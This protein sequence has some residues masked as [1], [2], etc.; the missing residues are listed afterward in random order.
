MILV[1]NCPHNN[2]IYTLVDKEN[3]VVVK[4]SYT[5]E[6]IGSLLREYAGY[7][8]Y[9]RSSPERNSDQLRIITS[10][11][12]LYSRLYVKRFSGRAGECYRNLAYNRSDLLT[13]IGAY[14]QCWPVQ[15]GELVPLHGD[16]S[17]GNLIFGDDGVA[18]IDWEHFHLNAAPWGLDMANLLY[19]A[20]YFSFDGKGKLTPKDRDAFVEVR[21]AIRAVSNPVNGSNCTIEGL[22]KFISANVPVWGNLVNK[23]PVTKISREQKDYL[24]RLE[25][26]EA[27]FANCG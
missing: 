12:G 14:T 9:F 19:E 25:R 4:S 8:W 2:G 3:D 7:Q 10:D 27:A 26:S 23:L 17:L 21:E 5:A 20:A 6:G 1:R 11:K 22:T 18:I 16:Y 24:M 15:D 13:A